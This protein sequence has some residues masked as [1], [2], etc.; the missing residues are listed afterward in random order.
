MPPGKTLRRAGRYTLAALVPICA[1]APAPAFAV[2]S[3]PGSDELSP[4]L[5]AL[6]KPAVRAASPAEQAAELG[7]AAAGPGSLLREGNRVLVEVRFER[8][9]AAGVDELRTAGAA[10]VDVSRRYQT[11]TA[12]VLPGEMVALGGIPGVVAVTEVLEPIAAAS[13]CPSGA[14]VSEGDVQLRA[15][16]ARSSFGVDGSGVEVGILSD[17]FDQDGSADTNETDDVEGGDLPGT[18]NTCPDQSTPVDILEDL[19]NP[20]AADEGRAM[21]QIVHDLAPG[22]RISFATA[23]TGLTAFAGNIEDLA[24]AGADAIVDDVSYFEEPFFQEGPVGVAVREVSAGGVSYFSSAGN[25]NLIAEGRDIASWEAPQFR[26]SGACPIG[27][28]PYATSC[29]DFDPGAGVDS[30]FGFKVSAGATLTVD[31]QWAQSWNGVTTDIDAYLLSAVNV[32]LTDS[33]SF[34]VTVTQR[35]FEFLS[36]TNAT[37]TAQNVMIAINRCDLACDGTGSGDTGVPR[38]KLALLQNGGGVTESEYPESTGGDTVG[39]TIFGHNGAVDAISTGAI[40]YDTTLAPEKFSSRGP[41]TH[42]FGPVN[43]ASPAPPLP[44]P[45]EIHKPDL[46]ATDCGMT[47]FFVPTATPGLYRFC[48]TSAAAPHAAAVA[49]LM[50]D[51]NPSLTPAQ[52]RTALISSGRPVAGF[53]PDA[54]G[55]GLIDA[56]AAVESASPLKIGGGETVTGKLEEALPTASTPAAPVVP[57]P[58]RRMPDRVAPSTYFRLRPP[59]LL[60]TARRAVKTVFH[61]GS[62]ESGVAF[63]CKIDRRRFR[64]CRPRTVRRFGLGPHVLRVKARDAAG[65]TDPTPAIF[66][67]RVQRVE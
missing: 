60:L 35:P 4:R 14:I 11:V 22:A 38:L 28:P 31:L 34:N 36:W 45:Q 44:S 61:F 67:F 8:G 29:M 9:A 25:N 32:P 59:A 1:L 15:Q 16:E 26:N 18:L 52:T 53:G 39:P 55:A 27:V 54:V 62:N 66:R 42:Y 46:V 17:S 6:A 33:E 65:N 57:R 51:M 23:F 47:S 64:A 56:V 21:A 63:L 12:A 20:E 40:R 49:A 10:V 13:T 7:L 5:S 24:A 43:G 30:T 2:S 41:L 58:P 50:R 37:G 48:G 19:N 3:R